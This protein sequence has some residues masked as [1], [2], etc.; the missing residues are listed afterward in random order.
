VITDR[1]QGGVGSHI[2][3]LDGLR[4]VAILLVL[5]LHFGQFGHGL[6]APSVLVDRWFMAAVR[7]GWMG[8]DLFFV[9]SGFLITGIL[10]DTKG[11]KHYFG[12]FYARRVLRIF[13]L[14]YASL[15]L[16]LVVLPRLFPS[17]EVLRDLKADSLWYWTY[18]YNVK[19]A[20]AGFTPSSALGH[21]WSLAVEEQ[22]YLIW[23]VVVLWLSRRHLVGACW[24]GVAGALLVRIGLRLAGYEVAPTVLTPARMDALAIGGWIALAARGPVNLEPMA[25]WAGP[26]AGVVALPLVALLALDAAVTTVGY[27]LVALFFGA[28][29]IHVLTA[30]PTSA[31]GKLFASPILGFFGR[32]SYALYVFHFPL[33]WFRPAFSVRRVPPV[34]GSHLP[35]Y[36]LWLAVG[37][38][39]SVATAFLSWHVVE[40]QFLKLKRLVPYESRGI[41]PAAIGYRAGRLPD[42]TPAPR[43]S[44]GL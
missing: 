31:T 42:I 33:L 38:G 1:A 23:P 14:Y 25:R 19:V 4:G 7:T 8:V 9:L 11:S 5:I 44:S 21:F 26:V 30:S 24:V 13:P 37:V 28:I 43:R 6:P 39:A 41:E 2:P 32:Y 29:L 22:F 18:L 27:T 17:D 16:F 20:A 10:F 34:F 35:A 15:A 36:L 12:H 40:K 3:A